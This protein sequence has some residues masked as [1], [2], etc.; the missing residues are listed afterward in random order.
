MEPTCRTADAH[1]PPPPRRRTRRRLWR[2]LVAFL[3]L[4]ALGLAGTG[5]AVIRSRM[6]EPERT[7]AFVRH[8]SLVAQ[9]RISELKP[10][11]ATLVFPLPVRKEDVAAEFID[12]LKFDEDRR[13]EAHYGVDPR[14]MLRGFL[15]WLGWGQAGGGST[16]T[17]QLVKNVYLHPARTLSRKLQELPLA[18]YLDGRLGKDQLLELY[19]TRAYFGHDLYG[20]EA[21]ARGY[22]GLRAKCL[23]GL[24]SALLVRTLKAPA[25]RNP[26]TRR[27]ELARE[28]WALLLRRHGARKAARVA[29]RSARRGAG[30]RPR[31]RAWPPPRRF[32]ARDA[33]LAEIRERYRTVVGDRPFVAYLTI[34]PKL[35]LYA[36]LAVE[37][38]LQSRERYGFDQIALIA[39][40]PDGAVRALV[41]GVDYARS[42]WN[43]AYRALRQPGSA[44]KP[45]VYLAALEAG[46][47]LD[48][49]IADAPFE[50]GGYR[51]RNID[52]RYL[53]LI[54]LREALV[55]SRNV[56]TV[57][58]AERIGRWRIRELAQRL[59]YEG[60]LPDD[61]TLA[62]G[63]GATTLRDLV[64]LFATL[65]NGGRPVRAH[66]VAAIRDRQ[67]GFFAIEPPRPGPPVVARRPLCQLLRVLEEVVRRGTGRRAAFAGGHPT[68]GKTGT[69]QN[70]RDAWF[71]GFTAHYVTGVWVGRDDDRP[72]NGLTGGDLPARIFAGFMVDA[73]R[74]LPPRPLA[75]CRR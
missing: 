8:A 25:R 19:L 22:F 26:R 11:D 44:F 31:F 61:P 69:S 30:C 5:L 12:L 63:S 74:G 62:L 71:V 60:G 43:R 33:A 39:M 68:A 16:L 70:Y 32:Y 34:D 55:R 64:E 40:T 1:P 23:S 3:L 4:S 27:R 38:A 56:A 10:W 13:F 50:A 7:E 72:M 15:G 75:G 65:A 17:Q 59:G 20:V 51:P 53:G 41:G 36:E 42:S 45:V 46:A 47:K 14:G 35:Q 29:S 24:Q 2:W 58:L 6:P 73:H 37:R 67:G 54:S 52:R 18:L 28:A 21:A 66:L 57:R 9:K 48:A 49:L